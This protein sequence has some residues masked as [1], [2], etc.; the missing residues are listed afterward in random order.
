M[1]CSALLPCA[2]RAAL[3]IRIAKLTQP[4]NFRPQIR[5][6]ILSVPTISPHYVQYNRVRGS[7]A[8]HA[9]DG[10]KS[11][12]LHYGEYVGPTHVSPPNPRIKARFQRAALE[13]FGTPFS[14][15]FRRATK[16][17]VPEGCWKS[18]AV[19]EK[20]ATKDIA[21]GGRRLSREVGKKRTAKDIATGG[22]RLPKAAGKIVK[23]KDTLPKI[24]PS[25][26]TPPFLFLLYS[27]FFI[28]FF[29]P[30]PQ[31]ERSLNPC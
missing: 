5:L 2:L 10:P 18:R 1:A 30:A 14:P 22:R 21:P 6:V 29:P 16:D 13:P 24:N 31:I 17:G 4:P 20:R 12:K 11:R 19:G 8:E 25:L 7:S 3:P 9:T 27:L 28:L 23:P 26:A 15:I